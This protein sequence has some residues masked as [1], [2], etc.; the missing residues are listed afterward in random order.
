MD[1]LVLFAQVAGAEPVSENLLMWYLRACGWFFGP[2]FIVISIVFVTLVIMNWLT[3]TRNAI[4][5]T[6]MIEQFQTRL[7]NKE[8]QEAYELAKESDSLF[9]RVFAVGLVA[10]SEGSGSDDFAAAQKAM[11]DSAEEEVMLLEHRLSYLSTIASI[12]PMVGLLGTFW[13]MIES[14]SVIAQHGAPPATALAAG[15]SLALVTGQI[16]L[17]LAIPSMV[18]FEVFK[19]RL[20]RFVLELNIQMENS[21]KPLQRN[22]SAGKKG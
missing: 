9:G 11:E 10:M 14:F 4:V 12:S 18:L 3:I 19:N 22:Y 7:K 5:P 21:L 2:T 6:E 17:M 13:G 1:A 20:S 16:G 8:Y 15:I